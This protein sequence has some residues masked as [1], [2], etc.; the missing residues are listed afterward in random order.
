MKSSTNRIELN[1]LQEYAAFLVSERVGSV[2][3]I[4]KIGRILNLSIGQ[5][6]FNLSF[7]FGLT[8]LTRLGRSACLLNKLPAGEWQAIVMTR[9]F[10]TDNRFVVIGKFEIVIIPKTALYTAGMPVNLR[11][12]VTERE[13]GNDLANQIITTSQP[14]RFFLREHEVQGRIC[15]IENGGPIPA[16]R[17]RY[18]LECFFNSHIDWPNVSVAPSSS[19]S[20]QTE[21]TLYRFPIAEKIL[22]REQYFFTNLV[23]LVSATESA[24]RRRLELHQKD[25]HTA[26]L[27]FN[28]S[29]ALR[30]V[31]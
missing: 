9:V 30:E 18:L 22:V 4:S 29:L 17:S 24:I 14:A 6:F 19:S 11:L 12:C 20:D 2:G 21:L 5:Q 26:A 7:H 31:A 8:D 23:Q 28:A 10:S 1:A 16:R 13:I 27:E 25:L 3:Q 15:L